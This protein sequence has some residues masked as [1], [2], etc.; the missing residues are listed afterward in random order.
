MYHIFF[1]HYS[2]QGH[3]GCFQFLAIIISGKTVNRG[4]EDFLFFV[5]F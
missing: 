2:V 3:I 5:F 4:K 1:I